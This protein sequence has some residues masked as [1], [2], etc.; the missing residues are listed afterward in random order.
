MTWKI[1]VADPIHES[2]WEILRDADNVNVA[3]PFAS[4]SAL[5]KALPQAD[6]LVVRSGTQVNETLLAA[7][8]RL[9]AV[10]RAGIGWDNIDMEAAT[11]RGVMVLHVP[12]ANVA[13]VAEHTWGMLLALVRH[14][15]QGYQAVRDGDW[16][17]HQVLG[18]QLAGKALGIVGFGRVGRAVAAQGQAFGMHVLVYDPYVELSVARQHGVE[19]TSLNEL[20]HRADVV[21]LHAVHTPQTHHLMNTEAFAQMKP[22]A[23]LV[24]CAH[25]GLVDETALLAA[26]NQGHLAGAALD[27]LTQEP[28][29]ADHLLRHHPR[30][31]LVPHWNQNTVE[32]QDATSRQSVLNLLDALRGKDYRHVLN[33]PFGDDLPYQAAQPYLRLAAKMGKLQGQLA[34]GWITH[35]EVELVGPGMEALVRPVAAAMLAGLIKPQRGLRVNWISAPVLAAEQGIV[36]AQVRGLVSRPEYP[37]LI[38]ARIRWQGG[39]LLVAGALFGNGEARLVQY[40]QF[41]VDAYPEGYVLVLENHDVPGVIGRVGTLLGKANINIGRWHYGRRGAGGKAVSF[42]NVDAWV[43]SEI[44]STLT[45][46]PEIY[47]ARLVRL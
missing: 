41:A 4:R 28:P 33:L 40:N 13:A 6:A 15:P 11:R 38:A 42:I 21:T 35:F 24:N 5:L 46:V 39:D 29:P 45:E 34:E 7:A 44:L 22:T 27:T 37:R 20:L 36:M 14:I 43:P 12:E 26:L 18:V 9:K 47:S 25:A 8:P 1:L 3:G 31:V 32:S 10:A 30:V 23:Y 2:G 17:R 16:P 19:M